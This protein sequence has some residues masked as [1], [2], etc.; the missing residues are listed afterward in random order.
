M[1]CVVACCAGR[2]DGREILSTV[3]YAAAFQPLLTRLFH[4]HRHLI[5]GHLVAL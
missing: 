1:A 3:L 4:F 2:V 5:P